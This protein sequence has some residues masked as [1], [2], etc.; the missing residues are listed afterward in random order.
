MLF[1]TYINDKL[2]ADLFKYI[3]TAVASEDAQL[4]KINRNLSQIQLK[5]LG[6]VSE[7]R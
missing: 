3:C 6:I 7:F 5:D 2:F 1:Q 4:N